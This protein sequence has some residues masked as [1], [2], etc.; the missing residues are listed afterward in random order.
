MLGIPKTFS[1]HPRIEVHG[2]NHVTPKAVFPAYILVV[3]ELSMLSRSLQGNYRYDRDR[4]NSFSEP[5]LSV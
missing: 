2:A 1:P 4:T 5:V 3:L